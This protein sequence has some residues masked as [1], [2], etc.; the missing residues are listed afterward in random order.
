MRGNSKSTPI[1]LRVLGGILAIFVCVGL[2]HMVCAVIDGV[3][4]AMP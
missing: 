1:A 2:L 4:K 3:Q